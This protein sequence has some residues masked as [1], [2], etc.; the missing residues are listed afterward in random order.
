MRFCFRFRLIESVHSLFDLTMDVVGIGDGQMFADW[1]TG[2]HLKFKQ[3]TWAGEMHFRG[4]AD[5]KALHCRSLWSSR[6][7]FGPSN[8]PDNGKYLIVLAFLSLI[9]EI[10]SLGFELQHKM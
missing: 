1:E 9:G 6:F 3:L 10:S 2:R 5:P 7:H 4:R 8:G